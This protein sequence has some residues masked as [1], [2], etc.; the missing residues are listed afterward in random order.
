[1]NSRWTRHCVPRSWRRRPV[2]R[3]AGRARSLL[4]TI[5]LI[6]A[7]YDAGTLLPVPGVNLR[8]GQRAG[9]LCRA[10]VGALIAWFVVALVQPAAAQISAQAFWCPMHSHVRGNE[11]DTC[12]LCGMALVP[13]TS[14]IYGNFDLDLETRPRVVRAGQQVKYRFLVR[15]RDSRSVV[16]TY[17]TVHERPFH[18]FVVSH[19][20]TYFVH[21][22]PDQ[23][24][25]S[26][27]EAVIPLPK[28]GAYRLLADFVPAGAAP[29]WLEKTIVTSDYRGT[30]TGSAAALDADLADKID[31]GLRVR[32]GMSPP[33]AGREQLMSFDLTDAET[34]APIVD[35]EPYLGASGHLLIVSQDIVDAAHSHPV[36]EVSTARGP[37]VVF[38]VLFPRAGLYRVWGQFQRAGRVI[39]VS[40]TVPVSPSDGA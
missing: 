37:T 30:L 32:L 13:V 39:T 31:G 4:P 3:A 24:R 35:L 12:R 5:R 18:L 34:A 20:L 8:I 7:K 14:A 1:M 9:E 2:Q 6:M 36:A 15:Q 11:G 10:P 21:L 27:F 22:H 28:P 16:R 19:D 40:F 25:D 17:S 23:Q 26:S 38:Q 33:A 29:Q